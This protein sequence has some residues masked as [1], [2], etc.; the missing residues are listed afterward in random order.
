VGYRANSKVAIQFRKWATKTLKNYLIKGVVV[1][2]KR[3]KEL[4]QILQIVARSDVVEI[5]GIADILANYTGALTI[6]QEY[7]DAEL[8]EIDGTKPAQ[9]LTYEAAREFLNQTDFA[10]NSANF[11]RERNDSFK[12]IIANLYQTFA[13]AELYR[14]TEEKAANLLYQ[15]VKDHPFVDGNKRSAAALFVYFLDQNK[16]LKI[17]RLDAKGK[18]S[19]ARWTIEPNALAAMTLMIALSQPAEKENMIKLVM[20]LIEMG[21]RNG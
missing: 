2:E 14:S 21:A 15:I 16:L 11:A 12:G 6:L 4:N 7:D 8:P 10:K 1:N 17:A 13:G 3:L 5:S 19:G 20:N 9:N 18:K